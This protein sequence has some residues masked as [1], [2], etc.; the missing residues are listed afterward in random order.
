MLLLNIK[1]KHSG[2]FVC[3]KTRQEKKKC[4]NDLAVYDQDFSSSQESKL[5]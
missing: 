2:N 1:N 5:C 4:L 3:K